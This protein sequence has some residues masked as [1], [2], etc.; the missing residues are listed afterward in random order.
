MFIDGEELTGG[1]HVLHLQLLP[2]PPS[3]YNS[4]KIQNGDILVLAHVG[5]PGKLSLNECLG[6]NRT[7][8][9]VFILGLSSLFAEY[10]W[11]VWHT[12]IF[13]TQANM[14]A[15]IRYSSNL[16]LSAQR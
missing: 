4:N 5:C 2:P 7:Q 9:W 10:E 8:P 13:N 12:A 6:R 15:Y 14:R 1:L 3:S 16:C 11:S